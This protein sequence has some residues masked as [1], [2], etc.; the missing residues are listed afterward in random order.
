MN[1]EVRD[2]LRF[3]RKLATLKYAKEWRTFPEWLTTYTVKDI[4]ISTDLSLTSDFV[5]P[6]QRVYCAG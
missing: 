6:S 1:K 5:R 2:Y 4:D 3:E